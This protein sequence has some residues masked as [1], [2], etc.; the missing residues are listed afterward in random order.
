MGSF[1][2]PQR[3]RLSTD[4]RPSIT[5]LRN[6]MLRLKGEAVM[7]QKRLEEAE[8]AYHEAFQASQQR[9]LRGKEK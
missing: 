5:F 4:A 2:V 9:K 7:A 3:R 6:E 8:K 1:V